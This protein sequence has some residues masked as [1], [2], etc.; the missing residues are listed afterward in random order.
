[1][2]RFPGCPAPAWTT[3]HH[4]RMLITDP[5]TSLLFH[6]HP[7]ARYVHEMVTFTRVTRVSLEGR[8]DTA[9]SW[10]PGYAWTIAYCARC[11]AHLGWRFTAVSPG[12]SPRTFYGLTRAA[13]VSRAEWGRRSSSGGGG[14]GGVGGGGLLQELEGSVIVRRGSEGSEGQGG[15][16]GSPEGGEGGGEGR[17][18]RMGRWLRGVLPEGGG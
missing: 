7:C 18:A 9:H 15:G 8:P 3:L 12:L 17:L 14:G 6:K 5:C 10:F 13:L 1:M 11:R 16:V 2:L 4:H